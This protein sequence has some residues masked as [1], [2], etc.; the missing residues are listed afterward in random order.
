MTRNKPEVMA[1]TSM[2]TIEVMTA[3][4]F[5][6]L[7]IS[8]NRSMDHLLITAPKKMRMIPRYN[9]GFELMIWITNLTFSIGR[10]GLEPTP[11]I[12]PSVDDRCDA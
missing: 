4:A 8:K 6:S 10:S 12:R 11:E 3:G 2:A 5:I 1:M 7:S 9:E